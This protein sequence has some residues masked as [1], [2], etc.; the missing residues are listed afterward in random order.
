MSREADRRRAVGRPAVLGPAITPRRFLGVTFAG[1]GPSDAQR[2]VA[3]GP[4]QRAA[5][6][7]LPAWA[8]ELS[9]SPP[10]VGGNV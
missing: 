7:W 9:A 5:A 8:V 3:D 2:L 4:R 6:R 1:T 10:M